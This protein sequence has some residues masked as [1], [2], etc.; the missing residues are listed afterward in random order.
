MVSALENGVKGGKWYSLM[1][2]VYAPAT[3]AAAWARVRANRGAAGVDGVSIERF[4]ARPEVYLAELATALR[5]GTYCPQPV[6]RVEIPKGDGRTRPLGIP[7][8]KDRIVQTAAKLVLEPIFEAMFRP[9]SYGFRPGR[10]CHDALREVDGLIG[11]GFTYVIDADLE[12]YFDS[13]P[14]D[15][16]MERVEERISDG[17]VL[18]L[19]RGWLGQDI[20]RGMERW[21]PASG[22]PQ[23]AVISPLLANIY[24]HPLDERMAAHG[25]RMVRYADDFVVLC[26]GREAADAALALIR[27]WTAENGL[28][29]HPDKTRVGDCR[30]P[31]EGLDFLGYRFEA[32][33]RFV[34]KKSLIR[35]KDSIRA[36]TRRTRGQSLA[37]IVADLGPVLRGWFGYFKHAHPGTFVR[38]DKFVRRRLRAVLRKQARRPGSGR[39]LADHQRW[40]NA[41]FAQA[42]LFALHTAWLAA[43]HS[44]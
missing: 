30:Q 6:R 37:R 41:F 13:I 14:H 18:D 35:L 9:A 21:T 19:I 3:L 12:S 43:R 42:G 40:P 26:D 25:Y 34:R 10:G 22:T 39:T 20:L 32:G 1:D 15:R 4:A 7:V 31:G 33:R 24:L 2:K 38:I 36:K 23:G 28:R 44:R 27:A 16:L 11:A 5:A 8:V 17:R 29:L